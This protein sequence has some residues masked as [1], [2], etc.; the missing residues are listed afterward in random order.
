MHKIVPAVTSIDVHNAG[1]VQ[2][3]DHMGDD[4]RVANVA[5]VSFD[6]WKDEF[7]SKDAS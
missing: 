7:D 5:R 3:V 6:N 2:Y 4:L 1:H